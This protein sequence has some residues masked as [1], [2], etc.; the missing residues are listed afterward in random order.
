MSLWE[1]LSMPTQAPAFAL[2]VA[3]SG[4]GASALALFGARILQRRS[5]PSRYGVLFGGIVGLLASPALVGVGFSLPDVFASVSEETVRIPAERLSDF[6][7]VPEPET[8]PVLSDNARPWSEWIGALVVGAWA[9]GAAVGLLRLGAGLWKQRRIIVS[10]D[11]HAD[12]WTEERRQVLAEKVGLRDFPRVCVSPVAPMPMVVGMWR[13]VIVLPETM[14]ASWTQPQWEAVLLHE[15]AHIARHD[16]WAMLAQ[17]IAVIAFWWCPLVHL[18]ARRLND[19]R[20]SICDDFALEGPCD[21]LA[22]AQLLVETAERLVNLQTCPTPVGLLDS[23]RGGLEE[24]ITRLLEKEKRSMTKLS[25]SGKLLGASVLVAAC[26]SITAATAFSQAPPPQKKV[27]IKIVIDGK[28]IDLSDVDLQEV[29]AGALKKAKPPAVLPDNANVRDLAVKALA[30]GPD[31]AILAQSDGKVVTLLDGKTGKIV[32]K[33]DVGPHTGNVHA[34][35]VENLAK[36]FATAQAPAKSDPRIEELVKQAEAIKP[37]SGAQ[38]RAALGAVPGSGPITVNVRGAMPVPIVPPP[39]AIATSTTGDKVIIIVLSDGKVLHLQHGA[40]LK[41]VNSPQ[42]HPGDAKAADFWY[43]VAQPAG[44]KK[45]TDLP[46]PIVP[47]N[48]VKPPVPPTQVPDVE[49]I[50]RKLE[51]LH[52]ELNELRRRLD[53]EKKAPAR[54]AE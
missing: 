1:S 35:F 3:L 48:A 2:L 44:A 53:A 22:Y 23:A 37:G 16:P 21:C 34:E 42:K 20:E 9:L 10:K 24:R 46:M 50:A 26:M 43:K 28:E 45:V 27:Q 4:G 41:D 36:H 25:F 17:R 33:F 18:L 47:P 51:R 29:L 6:L 38:V 5:A 30:F 39:H 19:L 11:W 15:A 8:P 7:A 52:A 54:R 31:A 12:W 32:A 40:V 49:A 14:P 13:P